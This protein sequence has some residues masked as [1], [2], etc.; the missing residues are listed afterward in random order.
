[1]GGKSKREPLDGKEDAEDGVEEDAD[2]VRGHVNPADGTAKLH[3]ADLVE[4]DP[5]DDHAEPHGA[6]LGQPG[7]QEYV[8]VGRQ[9]DGE[10][11]HAGEAVAQQVHSLPAKILAGWD[12]E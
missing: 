1:M 10:V 11:A 2:H 6:A 8:E 4:V 12:A 9:V 7:Q 5:S 3:G